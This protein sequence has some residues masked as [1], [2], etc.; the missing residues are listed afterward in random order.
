MRLIDDVGTGARHNLLEQALRAEL[1]DLVGDVDAVDRIV[2]AVE[3]SGRCLVGGILDDYLGLRIVDQGS[4]GGTVPG[5][6]EADR[7]GK[8]VP[9]PF[10]QQIEQDIG[11]VGPFRL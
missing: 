4:R 3:A 11:K 8:H 7:Q 9:G 2:V 10:A 5:E 1:Q 6:G